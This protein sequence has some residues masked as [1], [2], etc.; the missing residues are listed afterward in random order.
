MVLDDDMPLQKCLLSLGDAMLATPKNGMGH[1]II[2]AA[3]TIAIFTNTTKN[4]H[5]I[6]VMRGSSM[7]N[8]PSL[9]I[10]HKIANNT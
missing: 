5:T 4:S 10:E 1:I 2:S 7:L 8:Y 6:N 3:N 9:P